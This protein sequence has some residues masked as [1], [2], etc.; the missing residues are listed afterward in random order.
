M[1]RFVRTTP[2]K[3]VGR[4]S[5]LAYNPEA[6]N[7]KLKNWSSRLNGLATSASAKVYLGQLS[8]LISYYNRAATDLTKGCI[9]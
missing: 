3:I 5:N 4:N 9:P 1:R 7:E 6:N 2:F 8:A